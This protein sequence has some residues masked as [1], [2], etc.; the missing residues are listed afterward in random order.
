MK[1]TRARTPSLYRQQPMRAAVEITTMDVLKTYEILAERWISLTTALVFLFAFL[2]V[3]DVLHQVRV[4]AI[5]LVGREI[6]NAEKRRQAYLTNSRALYEQGYRMVG[7]PASGRASHKSHVV[8]RSSKTACSESRPLRV[9]SV[10][11]PPRNVRQACLTEATRITR[12]RFIKQIFAG[13]EE[14]A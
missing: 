11:S 10:S 13:A 9:S 3:P 4:S 8:P 7:R 1:S 14:T 5:P 6:G 2:V 12:R